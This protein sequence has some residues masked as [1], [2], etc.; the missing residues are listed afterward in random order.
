M[1]CASEVLG[2]FAECTENTSHT[3][4]HA[5]T[6]CF[7]FVIP[8]ALRLLSALLAK[9]LLG[10][11]YSVPSAVPALPGGEAREE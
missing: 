11:G 2:N 8:G 7:R 10:A 3:F 4:P 5:Q 9:P 1:I 6:H